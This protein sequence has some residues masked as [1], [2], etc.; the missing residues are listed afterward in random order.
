MLFT[1]GIPDAHALA[2]DHDPRVHGFKGFVVDQMVPD[3]GAVSRDHTGKVI[4]V[5]RAVHG[6]PRENLP[7]LPGQRPDRIPD[8]MA[9][10]Q[11]TMQRVMTLCHPRA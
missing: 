11:I 7:D 1:L 8:R 2:F 6:V 9:A 10:G 3:M 5:S 4:A